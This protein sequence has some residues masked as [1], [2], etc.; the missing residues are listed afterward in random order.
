MAVKEQDG[1]ITLCEE[2][3]LLSLDDATGVAKERQKTEHAIAGAVLVELALAGRVEIIGEK[4]PKVFVRGRSPMGIPVLDAALAE[5]TARVRPRK[6]QEWVSHLSKDAAVATRQSLLDRGL[7]REERKKV[8]G[9]FPV[10]RFPE[11]DGSVEVEMRARLTRVVLEGAEPD[12]RT[13]ALAVL[14]QGAGLHKIAFP[15]ADATVLKAADARMRE[16]AEARWAQEAV[17]KALT[18]AQAALTAAAV[19]AVT[20]SG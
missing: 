17:R 1:G 20:A 15:G 6:A 7:V 3:M 19:A 5:I 10:E 12:A 9:L 8:L 2:L 18:G 13:A 16:I 11:A 4:A 14:V